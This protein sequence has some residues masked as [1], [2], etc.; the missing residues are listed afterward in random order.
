MKH[1][2]KFS[3][4]RRFKNKVTIILH[5]LTTIIMCFALFA[6]KIIVYLMPNV[7][8]KLVVYYAEDL[9]YLFDETD[10]ELFEF[11]LGKSDEHINILLEDTFIIESDN[12]LDPITSLKL[13]SE[14][15]SVISSS[16]LNTL[17]SESQIQIMNNISPE[18]NERIK[19]ETTVSKDK[20]NMSMLLITGIYFAMLSF[21][22]MIANEVVYEKTSKVL[23]LVLTSVSTTT[24]YISKMI[25]A[26]LTV[27]IQMGMLL[28]EAS[29]VILIRNLYDE[30]AGLLSI[31]RKYDLLDIEALTF[32]QLLS[33]L[34]ID[35]NLVMI[36]IVSLIYMLLGVILVQIIMV[37]VS[38]FINSIEE[39][40]GMHAPIYIIFLVVYYLALALNTPSK[41]SSGIGYYLSLVPITSMLFMPMRLLLVKVSIYEIMLGITFSIICLVISIF[42]GAKI[43]NIGILGGYTKRKTQKISE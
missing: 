36:I 6:D 19:N 23:E 33:E 40:S 25:I 27:I 2:I 30:G 24:H 20:M 32:R 34:A 41:L 43:Y 13:M 9:K 31:L 37:C 1:L 7:E 11:K 26:W 12:A 8:E 15:S 16:W 14:I 28:F 3:I 10:S 4:D 18:I 29:A 42:Y 22:T 38:S 39:S 5:V 35:Q 17:S 21:S